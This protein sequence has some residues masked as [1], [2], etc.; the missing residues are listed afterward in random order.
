MNR[1]SI[2]LSEM[3]KEKNP[4]NKRKKRKTRGSVGHEGNLKTLTCGHIFHRECI[5]IWLNNDHATCP[6]CKRDVFF[7]S[8]TLIDNDKSEDYQPRPEDDRSDNDQDTELKS[9]TRKSTTRKR[10][11]AASHA[12]TSSKRHKSHRPTESIHVEE[13]VNLCMS[14]QLICNRQQVMRHISQCRTQEH[15]QALSERKFCWQMNPLMWPNHLRSKQVK[16]LSY[17]SMGIIY[18]CV[19][20]RKK[21]F[22][23]IRNSGPFCRK[24]FTQPSFSATQTNPDQCEELTLEHYFVNNPQTLEKAIL[25]QNQGSENTVYAVCSIPFVN[26]IKSN[27]VTIKLLCPFYAII[28]CNHCGL[29][30][31][32]Q[33]NK[34][35]EVKKHIMSHH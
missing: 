5:N 19:R 33:T 4:W 15:L 29:S 1:C 22:D 23:T 34:L 8:L 16:V 6:M 12:N 26:C 2:C 18:Q 3:K 32:M 35:Q 11:R 20:C 25:L 21:K 13:P 17:S 7:D 9:T 28:E 31:C 30:S 10:K 24:C 27:H 14:Y